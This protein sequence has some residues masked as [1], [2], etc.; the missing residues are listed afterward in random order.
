MKLRGT[1]STEKLPRGLVHMDIKESRFKGPFT[2]GGLPET[3]EY[4]GIPFNR[5]TGSL[6]LSALP[7]QTTL[8]IA[9]KNKFSG[10][11]SLSGLPEGLRELKLSGILLR[12]EIIA[13][14]LPHS[15]Q[16]LVL[17]DNDFDG[18]HVTVDHGAKFACFEIDSIFRGSVVTP[19]GEAYEPDGLW[20]NDSPVRSSSSDSDDGI[21]GFSKYGKK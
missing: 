9:T 18:D 14:E 4:I 21:F 11:I 2:I 7:R 10:T 1:V 3:I 8:F 15:L 5:F 17:S 6:G 13:C 16:Y 19:D 20:L 12:G